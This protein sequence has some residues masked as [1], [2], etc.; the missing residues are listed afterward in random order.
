MRRGRPPLLLSKGLTPEKARASFQRLVEEERRRTLRLD[1]LQARFGRLR[2]GLFGHAVDTAV[3]MGEIIL[4]ARP[5][6]AHGQYLRW[7]E[8]NLGVTR[9]T[10]RNYEQLAAWARLEP[11]VV[12]RFKALGPRK[13][14]GVARLPAPARR[15]L[16]AAAPP[17]ALASLNDERFAAR[18][19]PYQKGGRRVSVAARANGF[20]AR[21]DAWLTK[22]TAFL[23]ALD[24]EG[25]DVPEALVEKTA[26]LRERLGMLL[27]R[28]G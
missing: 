25:A 4:E 28:R 3:G 7:V 6:L 15:R 18:L 20:S 14:Y 10:A 26:E 17:E 13:L 19:A 24:D 27:D 1:D 21:V 9:R 22:T 16:L 8:T 5:L 23:T 2:D 11:D 12:A